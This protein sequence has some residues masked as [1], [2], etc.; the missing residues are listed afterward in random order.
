MVPQ[1]HP[2]PLAHHVIPAALADPLCERCSGAVQFLAAHDAPEFLASVSPVLIA[3]SGP[4]WLAVALIFALA[5]I[6]GLVGAMISTHIGTST[7]RS[8]LFGFGASGIAL[9]LG[10][11]F[12]DLLV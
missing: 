7:G 1:P 11:A 9:G 6:C 4:F 3:G 8:I 5:M 2:D 12:L 10:V